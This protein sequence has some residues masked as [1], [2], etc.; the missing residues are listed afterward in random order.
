MNFK[1]NSNAEATRMLK[2]YPLLRA[3][4]LH[5]DCF[6]GEGDGRGSATTSASLS[7]RISKTSWP[8]IKQ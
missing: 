7:A 6:M 5:N 8:A 3:E 2:R 4:V 1:V